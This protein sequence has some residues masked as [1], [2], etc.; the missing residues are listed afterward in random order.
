MPRAVYLGY[1]NE[2]GGA[3]AAAVPDTPIA[4]HVPDYGTPGAHDA[5]VNEAAP[6]PNA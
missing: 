3:G 1:I 6:S 4:P 5:S 2:R